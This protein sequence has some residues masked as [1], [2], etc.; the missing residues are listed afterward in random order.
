VRQAEVLENINSELKVLATDPK[1]TSGGKHTLQLTVFRGDNLIGADL[2]NR[3]DPYCKF[4][5]GN[6]TLNSKRK[7]FSGRTTVKHSVNCQW[8]ETFNFEF[9]TSPGR[10]LTVQVY[11]KDAVTGDDFMGA[12]H[13][14]LGAFGVNGAARI[15]LCKKDGTPEVN[16]K[17]KLRSSVDVFWVWAGMQQPQLRDLFSTLSTDLLS[18]AELEMVFNHYDANSNKSLD[19]NEIAQLVRH[20]LETCKANLEKVLA[21]HEASALDEKRLHMNVQ[22]VDN[23][24][25]PAELEKY[26]QSTTRMLDKN[27]D[28][29]VTK[30]EFLQKF[31]EVLAAM[32]PPL[33]HE[34]SGDDANGSEAKQ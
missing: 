10:K 11:D 26:V 17:T 33:L 29:R 22:S 3:S 4:F 23:A 13:V 34:G 9:T 25:K 20:L 28:F 27:A 15:L 1:Q 31:G 12:G 32:L 6:E 8:Q 16:A 21:K 2:G 30:S 24:L 14:G 5:F 19:H 18:E 7:G